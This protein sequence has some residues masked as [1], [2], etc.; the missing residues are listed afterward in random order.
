MST[1]F[2]VVVTDYDYPDLEIEASILSKVGAK[3]VG[4]QC[5]SDDEVL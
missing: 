4:A 1:D 3:V 2:K 5:K